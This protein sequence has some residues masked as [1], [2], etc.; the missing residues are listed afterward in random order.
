MNTLLQSKLLVAI[1]SFLVALA[2]PATA[3]PHPSYVDSGIRAESK[4]IAH[5]SAKEKVNLRSS[6]EV[7][8]L[9]YSTIHETSPIA[10]KELC[11]KIKQKTGQGKCEE[12]IE[13]TVSDP[14]S[15]DETNQTEISRSARLA[16]GKTT[17]RNWKQTRRPKTR[18][19][20]WE[21]AHSGQSCTNGHDF[22]LPTHRCDDSSGW[23]VSVRHLDCS[24]W[25][26]DHLA[27]RDAAEVRISKLDLHATFVI[28]ARMYRDGSMKFIKEN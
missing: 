22:W 13:T 1:A 25:T 19:Y 23:G 17:C 24:G 11:E 10:D 26:S 5:F 18:P 15:I 9:G 28:S 4:E 16:R 6:D 8:N 2:A 14:F 21:F 3:A 12:V 7:K 20:Y 27:A